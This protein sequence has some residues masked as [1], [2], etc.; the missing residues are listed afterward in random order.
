MRLLPFVSAALLAAHAPAALAESKQAPLAERTKQTGL[1]LTEAQQA[2]AMPYLALSIT[3]DPARKAISGEARY[4]IRATAPLDRVQFDLDPR[5]RISQVLVADSPLAEDRWRND[6]GLLTIDLPAPLAPAAETHVSIAYAGSP[7]VAAN[8]PWDGGFVWSET[9]GRQPWIA[10]AIQ[11]EGCDVFWPCIDNPQSRIEL[12]DLAVTV[13]EPLVVAGNGKL[14]GEQHADG[15]ATWRWRAK[16]PNNYGVTIQAGP[17]QVAERNYA[18]RFGNT[19]PLMFWHLPGH[20]EG[21]NSLL[22]ELAD[23]LDFF[24]STVG[25]Y[26]FPGEKAGVAETP[27][28][29]MEHQTINAYGHGFKPA[30]EGYDWLLQ[31][32]FAHEWFAN[33]ATNSRD[34]EMWLHE[35]LGSYMQPLYLRWKDGEL[36]YHAALWEM[37]KKIVSKVPLVPSPGDPEPDYNDTESGWGGDIYYKG[38]WIVHTL[39]EQIGDDA[40]EKVLRLFVYGRDDPQPGNFAPVLRTTE[41]L[42]QIVEQVTGN[43]WGWFF[44]TYVRQAALPELEA[45][46]DGGTL[47]LRWKTESGAAFPLPIEVL[48]G[49]RIITVP[50]TDGAGG[51]ALSGPN[52]HVVIDPRG[53]L[54]RH[55]PAIADWK[56]WT[57]ARNATA[58]E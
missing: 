34:Q 32:E 14:I 7:F 36:A 53:K 13:P 18:S 9:E 35:G 23:L 3:V 24:E 5:F 39:R 56:A 40:F 44:D 10:S 16:H 28:L 20:D 31:H 25:P 6:G 30:P 37:R 29:G 48:T 52:A 46:R 57:E 41:D 12:L 33:Q 17:Y 21:A 19:I 27:H 11:G 50:M 2:T 58:K 51:L 54:L 45:T 26:P 43:E 8:A 55:D 49:G 15:W 42:E 4:R 38:A 1:P 22:A 47:R